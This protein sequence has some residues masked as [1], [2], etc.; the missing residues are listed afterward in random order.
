MTPPHIAGE[1]DETA[2]WLSGGHVAA[3]ASVMVKSFS[4][5]PAVL[6]Q[7]ATGALRE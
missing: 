2:T 4:E 3:G 5:L 1:D 6:A 7:Q